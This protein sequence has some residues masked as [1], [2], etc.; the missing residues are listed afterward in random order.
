L[1]I[2]FL[3]KIFRPGK[4]WP[5]PI[6]IVGIALLSFV[7]LAGLENTLPGIISFP[8]SF[9]ALAV[10][11]IGLPDIS[12]TTKALISR[13]KY[14]NLYV[15]DRKL[16]AKISI[17]RGLFINLVFVVF[18]AYSGLKYASFWFGAV[19][20]YYIILSIMRFV[21]FRN[22]RKETSREKELRVYRFCGALMFALN[23]G[24]A[25]MSVQMV[26][27]NK[28]N[29]YTDFMVIASATYTFYCMVMAIVSMIT[30]RK[31][32]SP[33]LSAA[34]MLSFAAAIMSMF[35]LQTVL[36]SHFGAD[37]NAQIVNALSGA[38][39]FLAVLFMALFMVLTANRELKK[40]RINNS[41]TKLKHNSNNRVVK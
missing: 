33:V 40:F 26:I 34:K 3:R 35:T 7:F 39:V 2:S 41:Q 11:G 4:L 20:V 31:M 5:L 6:G 18:Y 13:N 16:R 1:K 22:V 9:Y 19:A 36:L 37:V 32:H 12:R 15:S 25:G 14:G 10:L 24:M 30:V 28:A 21:L 8:I 17:Y 29:D 38:V 23:L 27:Q